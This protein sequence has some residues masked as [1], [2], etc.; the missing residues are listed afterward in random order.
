MKSLLVV[1]VP[2]LR[3]ERRHWQVIETEL[4]ARAF[5][6]REV[7]WLYFDHGISFLSRVGLADIARQLQAL[8]SQEWARH[9]GY[10]EV[11]LTGHSL[12]ALVVRKA[13]LNAV[14]PSQANDYTGADWGTK[15]TRFVLFAGVSRGIETD[16]PWSRRIVSRFI[17]AIP[18]R[19]TSE[20]FYRGS[21]FITNLRISWVRHLATLSVDAQ[22][23]TVQFLGT[24]DGI[25]SR[26][27]S[28]DLDAFPDMP[29]VY[30][31][32]AGH[33]DLHYL[34]DGSDRE[35]RLALFIQA[36]TRERGHRAS[37]NCN[38]YSDHRI[39]MIV[40]GIRASIN[41]DW[42]QRAAKIVR[43]RWPDVRTDR[44]T[45]LYLSALR[46]ALPTVRR[47]YARYF[48]D[49]YTEEIARYRRA[50][51]S[52]LCHSN[53]TY[54]VGQ[55]L[56]EFQ[57][58]TVERVCLAGSVLPTRYDWSSL[59][60]MHRV[61]AVRNDC[62]SRDFPVA[63]LCSALRALGMKDVGTG[64]FDG[65]FGGTVT[66]VRF[67]DGG[68]GAMFSEENLVSMLKFLLD[69]DDLNRPTKLLEDA[70]AMRRWSRA[71]PYVAI[72]LLVIVGAGVGYG[73]V[74]LGWLFAIVCF[75][76]FALILIALDIV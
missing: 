12:G 20:D 55:C 58:I 25:V 73:T 50:R 11:I 4:N 26:S 48:R 23:L 42:V 64:G 14:D 45:Y 22:P 1:A 17:E 7:R 33:G 9:G 72:C 5:I 28:I 60:K 52:I 41:D 74:T 61:A 71:T 16:Q 34:D 70:P 75:A 38:A 13:W 54:S 68:H 29:P 40:H 59:L 30:I 69:D 31:P 3:P 24:K 67:H 39:L 47:R 2:G 76:V 46:F 18:G 15:V 36:F 49:F 37:I 21:A 62:G 27:D 44:P 57:A 35:G 32:G 8:I 10:D 43:D 56:Q 65:F 51:V 63:V 6:D 66:E 19:F 53:G